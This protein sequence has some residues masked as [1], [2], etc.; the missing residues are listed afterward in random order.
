MF[1]WQVSFPIVNINVIKEHKLNCL[2]RLKSGSFI[3]FVINSLWKVIRCIILHKI[4]RVLFGGSIYL[5]LLKIILQDLFC[6]YEKAVTISLFVSFF[7][8]E[9]Q[10]KQISIK[11]HAHKV[12]LM[13]L[14]LLLAITCEKNGM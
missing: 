4:K 7:E 8:E 11:I 10:K 5:D 14:N 1:V 13:Q 12:L 2:A 6:Q 9:N 3:D